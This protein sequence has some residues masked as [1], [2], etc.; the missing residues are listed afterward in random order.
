VVAIG[1]AI[2]FVLSLPLA[3]SLSNFRWFVLEPANYLKGQERH[4]VSRA[5]GFERAE[6]AA[7]DRGLVRYFQADR[8][9]LQAS[10][11]K[12]GVTRSPFS[13]RDAAHL[14]DVHD[15]IRGTLRLQWLAMSY[16]LIFLAAAIIGRS[17]RLA[18]RCLAIGSILTAAVF[19]LLGL[20]S[21][22]DWDTLFLRFHFVSFSNDLWRLDPSRDALIR[23]Y[24]PGFFM[25]ATVRLVAMS[26][27]EALVLAIASI[28][29]LRRAPSK[30]RRMT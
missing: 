15:L 23:L 17:W 11:E 12:E 28:A 9:S 26:V 6:L 18:A 13:E 3:L 22:L 21:L 7:I 30:I 27:A 1:A 8:D 19:G 5:T 14:L 2:V 10:L 29:W 24:P 20:L 4:A 16:G 25:D